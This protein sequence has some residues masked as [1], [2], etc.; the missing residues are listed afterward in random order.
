VT[1]NDIDRLKLAAASK[2]SAEFELDHAVLHL[3]EA[4]S[5]ALRHGEDPMVIAEAADLAPSEVL[6][7]IDGPEGD[8]ATG[9][10]SLADLNTDTLSPVEDLEA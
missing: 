7:L 10:Y 5:T 6:E 9:S 8:D 2:E 3:Q 4:V 1:T